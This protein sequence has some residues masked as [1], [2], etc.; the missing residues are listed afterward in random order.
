[1][2]KIY[3]NVVIIIIFEVITCV[4]KQKIDWIY[5]KKL[6]TSTNKLCYQQFFFPSNKCLVDPR[7]SKFCFRF[8]GQNKHQRGQHLENTFCLPIALPNL[9]CGEKSAF[10]PFQPWYRRSRS[11]IDFSGVPDSTTMSPIGS[12]QDLICNYNSLT[13]ESITPA[14]ISG[15]IYPPPPAPLLSHPKQVAPFPWANK[16]K[17]PHHNMAPGRLTCPF[18]ISAPSPTSTLPSI[19]SYASLRG[20]IAIVATNWRLP[21]NTIY[22]Y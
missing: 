11:S 4:V 20:S 14:L 16:R 9:I 19:F 7:E 3:I 10:W 5:F 12:K 6:V 22:A 1:M 18:D 17:V 8:K 15:C 21:C 2:I 13:K